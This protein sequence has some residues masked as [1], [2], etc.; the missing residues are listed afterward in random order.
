MPSQRIC[1]GVVFGGVSKEHNVSIK[2]A[3]TVV[4]ALKSQDN[5]NNFHVIPIYIDQSGYWWPASKSLKVLKTG[6]ALDC[7]NQNSLRSKN[8]GFKSL[9]TDCEDIE[10][11]FPVLHGPNG[12]DGTIQG[13]FKLTG[14]PFVGSGIL[15]SSLGMDKIAMKAIFASI[16]LP[17]VQYISC[18]SREI[19]E[20]V[21]SEDLID[22]I[23]KQIGYPCFVKPANLGS[24]VGITKAIDQKELL[25]GLRKAA[26]L[27]SRL[28]IE[29]G[30]KARELECAVLGGRDLKVSPVGEIKFDKDWYDFD[31]KYFNE[32]SQISIPACIPEEIA[33]QIKL[34]TLAACKAIP[35][36]GLARVDFFYKDDTGDLW[37]NEINTLPGFTMQSMYPMLWDAAGIKLEQLVAQLVETA[38]Q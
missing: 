6:I 24:S 13:F 38:T 12:E 15:G 3:Q 17:Q 36:N 33:K 4:S 34:L 27:D 19:Q 35:V 7:D 1:V 22:R 14:K 16:N 21:P 28:V 9:P 37:I 20:R 2:S 23:E 30:V 32:S 29:K 8:M 31:T 5:A 18:N 11:W 26:L 10:V 25:F